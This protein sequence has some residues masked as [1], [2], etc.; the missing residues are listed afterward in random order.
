MDVEIV[1][2][3]VEMGFRIERVERFELM[4]SRVRGLLSLA[5]LGYS[6]EELFIEDQI[7]DLYQDLHKAMAVP[8]HDLF[9]AI[10]IAGRM[11]KLDT[12]LIKYYRQVKQDNLNAARVAIR[13]LIEDEYI[14][15]DGEQE[16]LRTLVA[17]LESSNDE[18]CPPDED[19]CIAREL[20][21][22]VETG[23]TEV[24]YE[25]E[26]SFRSSVSSCGQ[27]KSMNT[28]AASINGKFGTSLNSMGVRSSASKESCRAD[29]TLELF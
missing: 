6:A 23:K 16:A 9:K 13:M 22:G 7:N 21:L 17:Y 29:V 15:P 28:I 19:D 25:K 24:S 27:I 11:Q 2:Q 8:G 12:E 3:T 4:L 10:S 5:E 1:D 14:F 26:T 20:S 18:N